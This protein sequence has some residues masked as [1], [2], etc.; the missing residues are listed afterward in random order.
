[1]KNTLRL[2]A[3]LFLFA[4]CGTNTEQDTQSNLK[5]HIEFLASDE[6]QGRE[7]GMEGERLTAEYIAENFTE[8]GLTPIGDELY[9][10]YFDFL[11]GKTYGEDDTFT[12]DGK[13]IAI[14]EDYFPMN[15][16]GNST[17][18]STI[19][20]AGFGINAPD[21][22]YND[23]DDLDLQGKVVAFSISSPDGIHPHSKYIDYHD[24]RMRAKMAED[25]GAAAVILFNND[26][27]ASD[28]R[29]G[30]KRT[31][32][33]LS[34]PVIFVKNPDLV[35]EGSTAELT[36]TLTEDQRTGRNVAGMID[37]GVESYVVIGAHYDHLGYGLGGNSL[38]RGVETLVHNGA[39]DNASGTAMV[40]ELARD[41]A[42]SDLKNH[43]YIFIAFSGE[44][45]G[46][47]G[48]S[49]FAKNLPVN[50]D[51]VNYMINMDMVGRLDSVENSI[52]VLGTGTSPSWDP[53]LDSINSRGITVVK[54]ESGIG[55]S[56]FTSF[57]LEDMP[58][59]GFFTGTH[60]DYHKPTDDADKIN[61]PGMMKVYGLI[62]DIMV[63][64]DDQP[65]L[66]FTKTIDQNSR[67]TPSFNVTLGVVPSYMYQGTGLKV[68]GVSEGKP[69]AAAGMQKDD[70]LLKLGN[71]DI[72]D[73]YGYM[74]ALSKFNKGETVE[75]VVKRGDEEIILQVSF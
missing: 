11:A 70:I 21:L 59:L 36:V 13:K 75:A 4:S 23:Y 14:D 43:N 31:E 18:K 53:L 44:E 33:R 49:H 27:T 68:D 50:P 58:V 12:I 56:D 69:A 52:S 2:V 71:V 28:P 32:E 8:I 3:L 67:R 37:N 25:L 46:L 65:K 26:K 1:M 5:K 45:M 62:Y 54:S 17:A 39:D 57:Y 19:V 15:F 40:I 63:D 9:Y 16:T 74:D 7:T 51:A 42:S 47:Y 73:I 64:L 38:Y 48:S 22:N 29:K 72:A 35:S 61:Y 60:E 6:M 20:L 66:E 41:V 24:L 34:I 55:P 10:Q 30:Y